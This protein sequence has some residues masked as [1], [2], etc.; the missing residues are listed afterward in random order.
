MNRLAWSIKRWLIGLRWSGAAGIALL[1][2]ALVLY[3]TAVRPA[4]ERAGALQREAAE[5]SKS[6]GA[7][8]P[9]AGRVSGRSQLSNFYA[10]FP[11]L[12][13]LPDLLGQVQA[14]AERHDLLLEK[15]EYRVAQDPGFRLARY[16]AI[17]PVRGSYAEVRA[18]VNEVLEQVPS[19]ALEEL[20]VK[21]DSIDDPQ[22]QARVRLTFFLGVQ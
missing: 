12:E 10:F 17:F 7:R 9:D 1:A 21:R 16:Q 2:A 11:L 8:G 20:V 19:A 15:G 5:L 13:Q 3:G 4:L 6:L 14:A 22:T 18:F